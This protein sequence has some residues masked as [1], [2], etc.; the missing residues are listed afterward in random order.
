MATVY[1]RKDSPYYYARLPGGKCFKTP[2]RKD[3]PAGKRQA[4]IWVGDQ[5]KLHVN[6]RSNK[7]E[8]WEE[9]VLPWLATTY[10]YNPKTLQRYRNCW[11][12]VY[13]FLTEHN[14]KTP[15]EMAYRH[16]GEYMAWRTQQKRRRGTLINHNTAITELKVLS[17]IM[18]EAHRQEFCPSNP[19]YQMGLKRQSVRHA[20]EMSDAEISL[21]RAKLPEYVAAKPGTEWMI[22]CFEIAIHHGV[23]L[24]ETE[25]PMERIDLTRGVITFHCKGRNGVPKVNTVPLHPALV[26]MIQKLKAEGATHTCRLPRMASKE[27]WSF[28][29]QY[30][31]EH[32]T[33]H[34]TR[35]VVASRMARANVPIQKA[36][37]YLAHASETIHLA[38]LRLNAGDLADVSA[39]IKFG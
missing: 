29:Q 30:G 2:F 24:T 5:A 38:Y 32:T 21:I 20:P 9:W 7:S 3:R 35:T 11:S 18:R 22:P 16:A 19:F 23:R 13:E 4:L 25:V 6:T 14:L 34:S 10:G 8:R 28:R 12:A 17:R 37:Q 26:P 33:F 31:L 39:A 27:W 1:S 15:R 36:K